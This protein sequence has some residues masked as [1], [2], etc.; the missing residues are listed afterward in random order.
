MFIS[1]TVLS[2][3][4]FR[5][6]LFHFAENL[7]GELGESSLASLTPCKDLAQ[8]EERHELLRSWMDCSDRRGDKLAPWNDDAGLVTELD[9]K[10]VV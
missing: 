5:K 8:L 6:S 9:R 10:S 3:L 7:R 2:L 1:E 4:D